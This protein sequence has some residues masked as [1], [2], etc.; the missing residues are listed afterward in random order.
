M[1]MGHYSTSV[2][3]TWHPNHTRHCTGQRKM[4]LPQRDYN[5]IP[6]LQPYFKSTARSKSCSPPSGTQFSL[7]EYISIHKSEMQH[8]SGNAAIQD[9]HTQRKKNRIQRSQRQPFSTQGNNPG[10]KEK[11]KHTVIIFPLPKQTFVWLHYSQQ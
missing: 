8:V 5:L 4:S 11:G 6:I 10:V 3:I 9:T 2:L 1:S 7:V